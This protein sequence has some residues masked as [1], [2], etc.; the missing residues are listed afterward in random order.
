MRN[1]RLPFAVMMIAVALLFGACET[2][3][4]YRGPDIA[5][6]LYVS[7]VIMDTAG[8]VSTIHVGRTTFFKYR[9]DTACDPNATVEVSLNGGSYQRLSYNGCN[10]YNY[11]SPGL[12][13][14]DRLDFRITSRDFPEATATAYCPGSLDVC[15]A[16]S[17]Y[18]RTNQ[19]GEQLHYFDFDFSSPHWQA[20]N[21]SH[22][23]F[24]ICRTVRGLRDVQHRK[25][26]DSEWYYYYVAEPRTIYDQVPYYTSDPF[27]MV[28]ISE[29]QGDIFGGG[30]YEG[31]SRYYDNAIFLLN[32]NGETQRARVSY[33][34][35]TGYWLYDQYGHQD[36]IVPDTL[37]SI[38]IFTEI[39]STDRYRYITT[40]D[41]AK[42]MGE[43]PFSEP[44]Q[45]WSNV[46]SGNVGAGILTI[47]SRR[48][49]T[50]RFK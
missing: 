17:G 22:F 49:K 8:A 48:S 44:V 32:M 47:C 27:F 12:V 35:S 43:D 33:V 10:G 29:D 14:G 30:S 13:Y 9:P 6:Q 24:A 45:L 18:D 37:L 4:E 41:N 26:Q 7:G 34:P 25:W 40:R 16:D 2:T 5:P 42:Y 46:F 19:Y 1:I 28:D 39:Y 38:T 36:S 50:I 15:F 23:N 21:G 11:T 20:L 3:I 31:E